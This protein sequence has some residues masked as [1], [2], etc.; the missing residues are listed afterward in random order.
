MIYKGINCQLCDDIRR[1]RSR[2]R[3]KPWNVFVYKNISTV[4]FAHNL[5]CEIG[6][7][8]SR[9]GEYEEHLMEYLTRNSV[10]VPIGI[11]EGAD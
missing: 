6:I 7:S 10:A 5:I 9:A 4:F 8:E 1:I 11:P 3:I 2:V